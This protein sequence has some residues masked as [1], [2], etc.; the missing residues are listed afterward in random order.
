MSS[1]LQRTLHYNTVYI[2]SRFHKKGY[3]KK[4]TF[5]YGYG[6][7]TRPA[8]EPT[9][10][11]YITLT[12][13]LGSSTEKER[14]HRLASF[15]SKRLRPKNRQTDERVFGVLRRLHVGQTRDSMFIDCRQIAHAPNL[16]HASR[17]V[18]TYPPGRDV[19]PPHTFP[20]LAHDISG[21]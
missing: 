4:C 7:R 12:Y 18:R 19:L 14:A 9:H 8:Y 11:I 10:Y 1:E 3:R 20:L 6:T 16:H 15:I 5:G 13:K 2:V 17:G 21:V